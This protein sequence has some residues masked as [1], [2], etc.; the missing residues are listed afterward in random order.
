MPRRLAIGLLLAAV[1]A[2]TALAGPNDPKKRH[3]AADQAWARAIRIHRADLPGGGWKSERSSDD[4]SYAPKR[5]KRPNLSDLVATGEA[6]NPDFSRGGSFVG[7]GSTIFATEREATA[8]WA[9]TSKVVVARC[10]AAAMRDGLGGSG[11]SLAVRSHEQV[12]SGLA[13]HEL[14]F[15]MRFTLSGPAV[16]IDGRVGYYVFGRGRAIGAVMVVSVGKPLQPVPLALEQKL[17]HLVASRLR[18]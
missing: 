13:P 2:S 7:S 4:S 17:T 1:F 9:R 10:F 6:S 11:A 15:R 18:R 12:R 14:G 8:A 16:K 5:C 3:N